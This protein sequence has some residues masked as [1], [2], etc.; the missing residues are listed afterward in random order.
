MSGITNEALVHKLERKGPRNT[1]ELLDI[2]TSHASGEDADADE[3][4]SNRSGKKKKNN[5]QR[6]QGSLVAAAEKMGKRALA[7]GAPDPFEEMLEGPCP[8]HAFPVKH[9]YKD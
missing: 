7:E 1:K 5:K 8:N 3:G 4:G 2:T 6:H 9:L